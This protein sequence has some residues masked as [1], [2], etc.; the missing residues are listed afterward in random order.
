VPST[1]FSLA[2]RGHFITIL[3][4]FY[5]NGDFFSFNSMYYDIIYN[6]Y[7]RIEKDIQ[8]KANRYLLVP[9]S[10]ISSMEDPRVS[11]GVDRVV[12]DRSLSSFISV[13]NSDFELI[14][15]S[16]GDLQF[17]SIIIIGEK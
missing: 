9:S 2:N 11:M 13:R 14:P 7:D 8:T 5:A 6:N 10:S 17:N 3:F 15:G 4:V 12:V 16:L 1:P